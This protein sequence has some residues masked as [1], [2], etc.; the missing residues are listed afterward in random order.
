[1]MEKYDNLDTQEVLGSAVPVF[2]VDTYPLV[3]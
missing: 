1:M 2:F 3:N